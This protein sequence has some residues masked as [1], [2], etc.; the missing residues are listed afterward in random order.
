MSLIIGASRP[1]RNERVESAVRAQLKQIDALLDIRWFGTIAWNERNATPE[2]RYALVVRWPQG[3]PRYALIQSG[4]LGDD[5][6]DIL[7]WFSADMQN[8]DT[9]AMDVD[10]IE[11]KVL[12]LLASADNERESWKSRLKRSAEHNIELRRKNKND[13]VEHEVHDAASYLREQALG[14]PIVNVPTQIK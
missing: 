12:E 14:I 6:H 1:E 7:G 8:A 11:S 13:F 9:A 10:S 2:G 5:P 3:D 4:D